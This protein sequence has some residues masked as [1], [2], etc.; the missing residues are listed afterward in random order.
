MARIIVTLAP[1]PYKPPSLGL[2]TLDRLISGRGREGG[3]A[4]DASNHRLGM[5]LL[6]GMDSIKTGRDLVLVDVY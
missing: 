1:Q 5:W 4:E 6:S 2:T 3:K